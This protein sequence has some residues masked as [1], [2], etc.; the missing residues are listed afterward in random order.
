MN[1]R[2]FLERVTG[3]AVGIAV[4]APML[5]AEVAGPTTFTAVEVADAAFLTARAFHTAE[6]AR[7]F[8]VPVELLG[9]TSLNLDGW[10]AEYMRRVAAPIVR[11]MIRERIV[12]L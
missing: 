10:M 6:I 3:A 11:R 1:R 4:G 12:Q 9:D 8:A 7:L 2:A 5:A